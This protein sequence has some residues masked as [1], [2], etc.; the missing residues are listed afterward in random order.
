MSMKTKRT[1][2]MITVIFTVLMTVFL[3]SWLTSVSYAAPPLSTTHLPA[4]RITAPPKGQQVIASGDILVSGISSPPSGVSHTH[5]MVSVLLNDVKPYQKTVATG[6]GGTSDYS[7][8]H[9]EITPKYAPIK[10]GQNKIT[11]RITCAASP[12]NLTKYNSVN[13]TGI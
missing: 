12:S 4:V 9:Y 11:A 6:P 13:V 2:T 3:S 1:K 5:C 10:H 7:I 8:W